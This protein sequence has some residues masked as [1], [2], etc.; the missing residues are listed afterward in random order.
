MALWTFLGAESLLAS[1]GA[2]GKVWWLATFHGVVSR[3]PHGSVSS[4]RL[5][6]L[7]ELLLALGSSLSISG[8]GTA[9]VVGT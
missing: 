1:S 2:L 4:N 7:P 6:S 3:H 9:A 8:A 5:P